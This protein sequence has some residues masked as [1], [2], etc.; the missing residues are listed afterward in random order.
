MNNK[1]SVFRLKANAI[2]DHVYGFKPGF[3]R[4]VVLLEDYNELKQ[5]YD[6]LKKATKKA[7]IILRQGIN[8]K[9]RYRETIPEE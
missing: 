1:V 2:L 4:E 9:P 5:D 6:T 3:G 7:Q 8:S